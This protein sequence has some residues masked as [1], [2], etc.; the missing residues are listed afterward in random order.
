M[1]L[2]ACRHPVKCGARWSFTGL[3][4]FK[5]LHVLEFLQHLQSLGR[6]LFAA[7]IDADDGPVGRGGNDDPAAHF[8]DGLDRLRLV[9]AAGLGVGQQAEQH[10]DG[11]RTIRSGVAF[12]STDGRLLFAAIFAAF[13]FYFSPELLMWDSP[14]LF[15]LT[16]G[17]V[18]KQR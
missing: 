8:L 2:L 14:R 6:D 13:G 16:T 3:C 1:S 5:R 10:P 12:G 17:L 11:D 4:R 7:Q 9:G 15:D 18:E